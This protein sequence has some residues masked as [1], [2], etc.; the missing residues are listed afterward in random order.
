M[1]VTY[2][3]KTKTEIHSK[4]TVR[5]QGLLCTVIGKFLAGDRVELMFRGLRGEAS[6]SEITFVSR[7]PEIAKLLKEDKCLHCGGSGS[8]Y[9]YDQGHHSCW[10][11][12]GTGKRDKGR[13]Q[14]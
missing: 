1:S 2:Y 11:C 3:P 7:D 14:V 12:C 5:F 13:E 9:A 4:D 10:H 6:L 8:S